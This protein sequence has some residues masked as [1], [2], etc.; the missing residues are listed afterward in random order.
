MVD[1]AIGSFQRG[2]SRFADSTRRATHRKTPTESPAARKTR[3][4]PIESPAARKTPIE[5]T[6]HNPPIVNKSAI[7]NPQS[8]MSSPNGA[9]DCVS[10]Q[11]VSGGISVPIVG[12]Q[13]HAAERFDRQQRR[14]SAG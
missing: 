11:V 6:I 1:G 13:I 3:K 7:R 9:C 8:A 5:S 2:S 14:R 4:T 10:D 12:L